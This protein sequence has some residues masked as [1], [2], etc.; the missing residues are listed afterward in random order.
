[1]EY[2]CPMKK[3]LKEALKEHYENAV[4]YREERAAKR[5]GVSKQSKPLKRKN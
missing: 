1:M 2:W 4:A 5:K 3:K